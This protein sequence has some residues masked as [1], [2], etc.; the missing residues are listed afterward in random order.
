MDEFRKGN[1]AKKW[2]VLT[3]SYQ[4]KQKCDYLLPEISNKCLFIVE[5]TLEIHLKE[6]IQKVV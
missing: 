5:K 4:L 6:N 1:Q 3:F 2:F